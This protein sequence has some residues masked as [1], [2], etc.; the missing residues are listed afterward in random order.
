MEDHHITNLLTGLLFAGHET[1][2]G[3]A[4][5]LVILLLEHPEHM[6]RVRAEVEEH[7][8]DDLEITGATLRN[9]KYTYMAIDE[10]TRLRPS[11]DVLFRFV[12]EEI[13]FGEYSIPEGW[14]V[15]L[16]AENSHNLEAVYTDPE[17]F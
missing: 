9:L 17:R 6:A 8:G 12:E 10:T 4:A 2:A 11:A 15:I 16:N 7:V 3:Q 1:T 5:W 14:G 13:E